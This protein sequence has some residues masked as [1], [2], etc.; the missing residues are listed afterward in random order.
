MRTRRSS[1]LDSP[2]NTPANNG[3][4]TDRK[5]VED[6]QTHQD[7]V[8]ERIL[9]GLS[10]DLLRGSQQARFGRPLVRCQ[11]DTLDDL[12]PLQT[13]LLCQSLE[14]VEQK[15]L[16]RGRG[17]EEMDIGRW[18]WKGRPISRG[19]RYRSGSSST[20][21]GLE[22]GRVREDDGDGL[23]GVRCCVHAD[24]GD[25]RGGAIGHLQLFK[26][27]VLIPYGE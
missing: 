27:D 22:V 25:E 10:L 12:Y 7:L 21:G 5:G 3:S 15:V 4:A 17:T 9:D 11:N 13:R 1:N 20:D 24:V 16:Y 2:Y 6:A 26:G 18:V 19:R 14:I 23:F 8:I